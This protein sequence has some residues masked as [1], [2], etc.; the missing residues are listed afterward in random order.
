MVNASG[1]KGMSQA[2]QQS[3]K[4]GFPPFLLLLLLHYLPR[5]KI[6]DIPERGEYLLHLCPAC[7]GNIDGGLPLGLAITEFNRPLQHQWYH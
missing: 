7:L 1:E 5:L 4:Y 3:I 6:L 2:I